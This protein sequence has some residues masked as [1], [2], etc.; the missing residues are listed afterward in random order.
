MAAILLTSVICAVILPKW[1]VIA[2][3]AVTILITFLCLRY[4][5]IGVKSTCIH[6]I[7]AIV[8]F[9]SFYLYA[10]NNKLHSEYNFPIDDVDTKNIT[11]VGRVDSIRN[12]E[13][14]IRL[15]INECR[16]IA[17]ESVYKDIT[18]LAD[19]AN[20][21]DCPEPGDVV[22]ISG[23]IGDFKEPRNEGEFD[24]KT[25]YRSI[26]VDYKVKG[27]KLTVVK[28]SD[29]IQHFLNRLK[30][31]IEKVYEKA[32]D[33]QDAGIL[34]AVVLGDRECLDEDIY[35]LYRNNGIAHLL[36]ISSIHVS[37]IG[38]LIY[39]LAKRLLRGRSMPFCISIIVLVLYSVMTGNGISA[40]RAVIMCIVC[41]GADV[42]GRTYDILTG[43]S[44]AAILMILDNVWVI[45][46][47]GFQLSF[48]AI[49]GIAVVY[50]TFDRL[51][52]GRVKDRIEKMDRKSES[53]KRKL[54]MAA[55]S[56][57]GNILCSISISLVTMPV[58]MCSYY[59]LPV[60]SVFLNTIAIPLMSL[61]LMCALLAAL[62]GVLIS[63][64]AA[65][66]FIGMV[67][68]ILNFYTFLCHI[69]ENIPGNICV[70]GHPDIKCC[71]LF[72]ILLGI[73]AAVAYGGKK[74]F[75]SALLVVGAAVYILMPQSHKNL[76]VDMLDV[77][78]GD[79]ILVRDEGDAYLVDG[80]SSDV[81]N[82][83][84]KRIYPMLL[85]N[86]VTRLKYVVVSHADKDHISGILELM[87]MQGKGLS[88]DN[89]VVPD[90]RGNKLLSEDDN[91]IR[92]MNGAKE[93][94]INV[95][96]AKKGDMIDGKLLCLHPD[97]DYGTTS[98]ND[99]SA[100]Y[101][102][103]K[104]N[105]SLLLTGDLGESGEKEVAKAYDYGS[106][107]VLKVAHHGSAGS[108]NVD[109]IEKVCPRFALISCGVNNR[110]G[111]PSRQTLERLKNV[112]AKIYV[113]AECGQI[114]VKT[115]G[116]SYCVMQ[117]KSKV[118]FALTNEM[119]TKMVQSCRT[120]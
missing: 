36:A 1:C 24:E 33:E 90:I 59:R 86:G 11:L 95:I 75:R 30:C 101:M 61:L 48:G 28:E 69:F 44:I 88:I 71:V 81:T 43:L 114:T 21:S 76:T 57:A 85:Y 49:I 51:F 99:A 12:N 38:V 107:T 65:S 74:L 112:D 82:V 17:S 119:T 94:G 73:F 93:A 91:Y 87:G 117:K 52:L 15:I 41:I 54:Y 80:G 72:Y 100:V 103:Q 46:N 120:A 106:A 13:Y 118:F 18:V 89:I 42:I 35:K 37:F 84:S 25:Y 14:G 63:S 29:R 78:Q 105:F 92:L 104:E 55:V 116:R 39:K 19:M 31:E 22:Q 27:S 64:F 110:Y 70:T 4:R 53:A 67:H 115:D 23:S 9:F 26:K 68:Y 20:V 7:V 97:K 108:T 45:Y 83:G 96:Y 6:I 79:C 77:G 60:Y 111:H 47:T 40:R 58:I 56:V 50:P 109:F 113:T 34:K 2:V 32:A 16:I 62:A 66:F 10:V 5:G 3:L 98:L 102:L 8:L